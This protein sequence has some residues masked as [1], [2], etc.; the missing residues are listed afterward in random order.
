[1]K[2]LNLI[3]AA[4]LVVCISCTSKSHSFNYS[5]GIKDSIE[6]KIDTLIARMGFSSETPG[7]VVGVIIDGKVIFQKAYGLANFATK[8]P[9]TTSTLF[10]LGSASKQFTAAAVL[11]LAKEKKLA[12]KDDIR[13]YIPGFP[14]WGYTIT[15]ENLIHHTSGIRSCDVLSLMA[16]TIFSKENHMND[17]DMILRQSALNYKPGDEYLYSNSGYVLLVKI[18]EKTSGMK[19]SKF[20]EEKI[21]RPIGMSQTF[22]YDSPDKITK[23]CAAGHVWGGSEKFRRSDY[24]DT[25]VV[26]ESNEYTCIED[27][28]QWDNNFYRNR[29]GRWDFSKEMTTLTR[30]NNG[31]KNNYAFGLE[32]SEYKGL[33]TVSHGGGTGDFQAQYLQ[34]PSE[35]FAVVCLFN[36]PSDV[37][38]LSYKIADLFI[39]GNSQADIASKQ[40]EKV[41][42]DTTVLQAYT[43]IYFDE[44]FWFQPTVTREGD[45]LVFDA[46]YQGRFEIYPLSDSSF[47][48]TVADIRFIFSK[49][50]K[51]EVAKA[52]IIQGS[53]KFNLTYLGTKIDSINTEQLSRNAGDYYCKDIDITYPVIFKDNKL[54]IRFPEATAQF[55]NTK[56]ESELIS[57]HAD[58]FASPVSGL[59]FTRD[60]KNEISGFIL[61]DIGRVRNL[62]FSKGK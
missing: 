8:E 22:I 40:P 7:G 44:N 34:I 12:L 49:N 57:E 4:V 2:K 13:K 55:I 24:L 30:L 37:T 28:L 53:Q 62:V 39:K 33:K 42:V 59:Q 27:L 46:P 48:A 9:N 50:E 35:K 29:L 58:Y 19:F 10:N 45:H 43:G 23:T 6:I 61:K 3:A 25:S 41:K 17:Y 26:G 36:I 32:V 52:K 18:I 15:I 20:V 56:A 5:Q 1:M 47:F 11:L 38:G 60:A 16:G 51:G 21:L 54:Y 31:D 14:D